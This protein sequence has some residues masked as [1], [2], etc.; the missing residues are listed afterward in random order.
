MNIGLDFRRGLDT[1][2]DVIEQMAARINVMFSK[3]HD[4]ATGAHRDI[5][6]NSLTFGNGGTLNGVWRH[7]DRKAGGIQL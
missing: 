3:E 1:L 6:A 4:P 5:T 2:P 7:C